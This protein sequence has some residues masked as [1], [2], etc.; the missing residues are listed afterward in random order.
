V[1]GLIV[2]R[3]GESGSV[4]DRNFVR[5]GK[6]CYDARPEELDQSAGWRKGGRKSDA[7]LWHSEKEMKLIDQGWEMRN[8]CLW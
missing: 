5:V 1:E 7:G 3:K 2:A 8:V 6:F 4:E